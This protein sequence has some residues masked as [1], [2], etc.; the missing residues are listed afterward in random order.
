MLQVMHSSLGEWLPLLPWCQ[1][2][3]MREAVSWPE[4]WQVSRI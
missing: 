1:A 2:F 4:S 3:S